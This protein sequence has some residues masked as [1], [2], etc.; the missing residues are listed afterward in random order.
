MRG[1]GVVL[2]VE[3]KQ[4][5]GKISAKFVSQTDNMLSNTASLRPLKIW[6]ISEKHCAKI[7]PQVKTW[8]Q[9]REH[10]FNKNTSISQIS[11]HSKMTEIFVYRD[12]FSQ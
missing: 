10:R 7:L 3:Y 6:K 9:T 8:R 4:S 11:K 2:K 5:Y 12:T 1:E